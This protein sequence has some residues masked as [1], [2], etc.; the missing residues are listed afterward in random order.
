MRRVLILGGGV[1]G[2]STAYFLAQS[3]IPSTIIEPEPRLGGVMQTEQIEGC[4]VELGPDSFLTAKPAARQLCEMLGLS[5]DLIGSNDA[6]RA[7][8]IWKGGKLVRM[9][10]GF[11]MMVPGKVGPVL[12]SNLLSWPG[13][14]RAGMDLFRLPTKERRDR[15]ISEFVL[16]H[17]GQEVLDYIAEPL[18]AGVYGG[19]PAELSALSTTP[20]FVDWEARYGSLTRAARKEVKPSATPIFT[21]LKGGLGSLIAALESA[22]K[23]R[24]IRGRAE[25]VEQG[26]RVRVDGDWLEADDVVLA[27]RASSVLPNLFPE[28]QYNSATV[29]AIGY[30]RS[31]V[32]HEL[33]GFG[34]LV[35]SIER[36][37]M[38]ACTW[39]GRKFGY[40]VPNDK[41][42]LRCF[43]S[44]QHADPLPEVQEK[45]GINA[46]PLFLRRAHWPQSMPQYKVGHT[47]LMK[48]T[49]E[50]LSDFPGLH[51]AGNAYHGIGIP[52]CV[53]L[54]KQVAE[55]I[56]ASEVGRKQRPA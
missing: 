37:S 45:L 52:D 29:V 30:R 14:L 17:Y 10:E 25:A 42:L 54:S 35:P 43:L 39:V 46:E 7:T 49:D 3:G 47:A 34:F 51:L 1:S 28:I 41:V 32:K 23:P 8:F 53:R 44:S 36:K 21:T 24:I 13:K 40:R 11:T 6:G 18:L 27:C 5:S 12:R 15:S 19:D 22:A 33:P 55:R 4:T 2:L 26:W 16:D 48:L 56:A 50:M 9:P 20:K 31:D 38:S